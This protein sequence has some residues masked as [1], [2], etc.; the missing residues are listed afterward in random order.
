MAGVTR[1]ELGRWT[2][3]EM[4]VSLLVAIVPEAALVVMALLLWDLHEGIH[5][6]ERQVAHSS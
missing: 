5:H 2:V 6:D 4:H 3:S 1:E